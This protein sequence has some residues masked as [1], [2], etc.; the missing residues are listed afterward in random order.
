MEKY[1]WFGINNLAQ[2]KAVLASRPHV[3]YP[4]IA[5]VLA[6]QQK[7]FA[8][9]YGGSPY[10]L[11]Y[12]PHMQARDK[13]LFW[14]GDG[15]YQKDWGIIGFGMIDRIQNHSNI[16]FNQYM[17]HMTY[18]PSIPIT[19]YRSHHPQET[20]NTTFLK[21]IFGIEFRPLSK[22]FKQLGYRNTIS[23]ITIEEL[24]KEQYEAVLNRAKNSPNVIISEATEEERT[25]YTLANT[26]EIELFE[27]INALLKTPTLDETVKERLQ[28]SRIG[29]ERFRK[30]LITY[31][32]GRCA[33]TGFQDTRILRASHI[34]PWRACNNFE[35]LD[36]F[37]G[38]LLIPNLDA[39][40][41]QGLITFD[42]QGKILISPSFQAQAS[43]LGI[44]ENM[45]I[46]LDERHQKYLDY[47]R[48]LYRERIA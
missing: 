42:E 11:K 27:D 8:W 44:H 10:S 36:V 22:V 24:Q 15:A 12:Y 43:M 41:D 31:W 1:W 37:N 21:N 26:E 46:R 4:E 6:G 5:P 30:A 9:P 32:K 2:G 18:V 3:T 40:F 48:D 47:H 20:E 45:R 39:V 34:K 7:E 28:F 23:I 29:Q 16:K 33:I 13:V 35:R 25:G 17:L 14:M 19:P 38:L